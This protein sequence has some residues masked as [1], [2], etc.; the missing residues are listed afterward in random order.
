[1]KYLPIN[2]SHQD[3][4]RFK[5]EKKIIKHDLTTASPTWWW[6]SAVMPQ[7]AAR[8]NASET[9]GQNTAGFILFAVHLVTY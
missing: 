8:E 1:M 2:K 7:M 5:Q 4:Y 9:G 3:L 6:Y